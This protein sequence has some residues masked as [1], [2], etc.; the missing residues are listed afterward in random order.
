VSPA[1]RVSSVTCLGC[2]C[3]CDD[4]TVQVADG[5]ITD[6]TPPCPVGRAWFG[7]GRVPGRILRSGA[8]ASIEAALA[9]AA[10]T[11]AGARGG[12]LVLLAPDLSTQGQRAA[13]AVA[14]LLRATVDTA[15]SEPAAAGLLAAQRRGRAAATLG[16]VRNR[17]DVLLFWG[18]DPVPRYPRFLSRYALDPAGTHVPGGRAGRTVISVSIGRDR[19]PAGA[20]SELALAPDQEIA[21]LSVMRAVALGNALGELP[22]PLQAAAD[23]ATR[24]TT[25]A[26]AV[27]VHDGEPGEE[28]GRDA[29][30]TEGLIALTQALNGRTR[31]ALS[32]LRAGGNRSGAEAALTWQTGYPMAVS[33]RA[34]YPRYMPASRGLAELGT[35]DPGAILVAGSAAVFADALAEAGSRS[36]VIVIGPRA[37]EAPFPVRVAIDTGVAGIHEGGTAYRM[38]EVPL[39]LRPPLGGARSAADTLAALLGAVRARRT[40]RTA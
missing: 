9:D 21:A 35:G 40:G 7:D 38:D 1:G 10:G 14:D 12:A 30:R 3:G 24:L 13:L 37:S 16:E 22:P 29:Y 31:A 39:P 25:A 6:I 20:E 11:L 33:Y 4:L 5:R 32:T 27:L 23:A 19:G 18:V 36:P 28:S 17:A 26:Y 15:T 8:E 34:G 2:G